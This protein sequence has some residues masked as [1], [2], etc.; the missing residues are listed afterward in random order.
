MPS[1]WLPYAMAEY[2]G[3][4]SGAKAGTVEEGI[5]VVIVIVIVNLNVNDL[6]QYHCR[7]C[8]LFRRH[9]L[10]LSRRARQRAVTSLCSLLSGHLSTAAC[11]AASPRARWSIL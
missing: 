7:C 2:H 1:P 6:G 5:G 9:L 10:L 8:A 4:G 11:R 3:C